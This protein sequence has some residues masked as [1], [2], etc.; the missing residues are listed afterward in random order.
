MASALGNVTTAV[1]GSDLYK[2]IVAG[3]KS[4]ESGARR[5]VPQHGSCVPTSEM[6]PTAT[7]PSPSDPLRA[8]SL[9][10]GVMKTTD[11]RLPASMNG[12]ALRRET[13]RRRLR[14]GTAAESTFH[15]EPKTRSNP[16]RQRRRSTR[17][18]S[19]SKH[20]VCGA[21]SADAMRIFELQQPAP[22]VFATRA[23]LHF[24]VMEKLH[25]RAVRARRFAIAA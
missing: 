4:F 10:A 16:G 11:G 21:C 3:C 6:A 14:I 18:G 13:T 8:C 23:S 1:R 20:Q 25:P 19:P 9:T 5:A 17:S 22:N 24:C 2:S 12:M 7:V 15:V